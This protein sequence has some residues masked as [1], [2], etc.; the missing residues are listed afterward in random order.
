MDSKNECP[1][2][3]DVKFKI[4]ESKINMSIMVI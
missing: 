2:K 1:S 4:K 3:L